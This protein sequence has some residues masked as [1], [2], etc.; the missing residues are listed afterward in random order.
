VTECPAV[1]V[2]KNKTYTCIINKLFRT[3]L[4][5]PLTIAR[6]TCGPI[7]RTNVFLLVICLWDSACCIRRVFWCYGN[8]CC[9]QSQGAF[10]VHVHV[11][12]NREFFQNVGML[13]QYKEENSYRRS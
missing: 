6:Q 3:N 13:I 10:P 11:Q 9:F 2:M 7:R 1:T 12:V 8:K 5:I 4:F